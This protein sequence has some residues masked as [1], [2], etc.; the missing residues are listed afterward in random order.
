MLDVRCSTFFLFAKEGIQDADVLA[1][2]PNFKIVF[3]LEMF[4]EVR[5]QN[6]AFVDM[7]CC[8]K[9]S[10]PIPFP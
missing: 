9:Q 6:I 8:P 2:H 4:H 5:K 10:I 7:E 1:E 3:R